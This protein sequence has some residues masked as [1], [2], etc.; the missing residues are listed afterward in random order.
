MENV[1]EVQDSIAASVAEQLQITMPGEV[2]KSIV[3]DP[4][5]YSLYLQGRHIRQNQ[6]TAEGALEA[7]RLQKAA[8][9]IE[10]DYLDA[11]IELAAA[12][13]IDSV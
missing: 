3:I 9:E 11:W 2:P 12:P 7:E 6:R 5:A 8:L 1:F 13:E 10:P 4:R